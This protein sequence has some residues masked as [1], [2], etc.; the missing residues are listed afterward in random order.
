MQDYI[1]KLQA[2]S[3]KLAKNLRGLLSSDS[4]CTGTTVTDPIG[5]GAGHR[6]RVTVTNDLLEYILVKD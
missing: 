3:E 2:V 6:V 4:P 5:R 1:L